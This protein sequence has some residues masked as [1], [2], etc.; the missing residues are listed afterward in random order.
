MLDFLLSLGGLYLVFCVERLSCHGKKKTEN[1]IL[2]MEFEL[3]D[4]IN[5]FQ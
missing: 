3:L 2:S 1:E 5:T 4:R